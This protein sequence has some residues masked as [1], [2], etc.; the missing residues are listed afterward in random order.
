MW[1][2]PKQIQSLI[3]ASAQVMKE[4]D[5]DSEEFCQMS[6]KSLMW[7][8]KP[9]LSR[10]WSTRLKREK[11]LQLLFTRTLKPSHTESFEDKWTSLVEDSLAN[12]SLKQV[13][14]KQLMTQDTCSH[15]SQKESESANLEL[16]SSKMSKELS[17]PKQKTEN[18][19]SNM[20]SEHWKSWVT[21]QRQ[22]YSQRAKSAIAMEEECLIKERESLSWATPQVTDGTRTDVRKP[23]ERLEKAKKGGCKNLRE[24]VINYPTPRSSDAEGGRIETIVTKDGFKSLRKK[25]NQ[26][27]GA[28]LRD[29]VE[30]MAQKN[31]A[32]PIASE[33][34]TGRTA[35][36][37][38][39]GRQVTQNW[40]TP[41]ERDSRAGLIDRG[42]HNL[43]EQV[44]GME[45]SSSQDQ[46]NHSLN[47]K[48]QE[49]LTEIKN[50]ILEVNNW[51]TPTNGRADQGVTESQL[52]R[53]TLKLNQ[54][55]DV[56]EENIPQVKRLNPSW[57]EQLM[58]LPVGW[59]QI[60]TELTD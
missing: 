30:T 36:Q 59:T 42:K 32:T 25:S 7:R 54:Q 26:T 47:G 58:G 14:K 2:L 12:H 18:Q 11:W 24:D 21:E 6:E 60:G 44:H 33:A 48:N 56:L 9:S 23:S 16:F 29:A 37:D 52:K 10:T 27:F 28:K 19:F 5:L 17:A 35:N 34:K 40:G 13:L 31:W 20:S 51:N 57:V 43:G 1:I 22:E 38:S 15:T 45:N 50:Q 41:K 53:R 3:S 4:S 39:L 49:L 55:I 46:T 8:S